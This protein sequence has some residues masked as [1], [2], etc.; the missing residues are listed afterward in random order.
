MKR[1]IKL[2]HQI[3]LLIS[4]LVIIP[5]LIIS[6]MSYVNLNNTINTNTNENSSTNITMLMNLINSVDTNCRASVDF[7][8]KDP[9]AMNIL[10]NKDSPTWLI[11]SFK[12]YY[13][14]HPEF[15]GVYMGV[16]DKR[17]L[18]IP[19]QNLPAG[20]DPTGRPW[21]TDAMAKSGQV[22][23]TAP[24]ED[25]AEKGKFVVTYAKQVIAADN[26]VVG[27]VAVDVT[28]KGLSDEVM[29]VK[30]GETGYALMLDDTGKV[31]ASG[32][33]ELIGLGSDKLPWLKDVMT[34]GNNEYKTLSID[35]AKYRVQKGLNP[36]TGWNVAIVVPEKELYAKSTTIITI[37]IVVAI[38]LLLLAILI[39]VIFSR[40]LSRPIGEFVKNI[41]K[42]QDG[43]FTE[44]VN[45]ENH[46]NYEIS[47]IAVSTNKMI[48]NFKQTLN[49]VVVS[50]KDVK[51]A[52]ESL[53]AI[54]EQS[55][56]AAEEV[57]KAIQDIAAGATNQAHDL[58]NGVVVVNHLGDQVNVSVSDSEKMLKSTDDVKK[59]ANDGL[60]T[61]ETL[62]QNFKE[63]FTANEKVANEVEILVQNFVKISSITDTIKSITDQT[64]LLALNASIEAAR[65]GEAGKGFAVV[66]EEVRKLAEQSAQSASEI[67]NVITE[68]KGSIDAVLKKLSESMELNRRTEESV[69]YTKQSFTDINKS[70]GLLEDSAVNVKKSMDIIS[71]NKNSVIQMINGVSGVSTDTAAASEQVSASSEEQLAA[72]Q[73][74]SDL[75]VK[76]SKLAEGLENSTKMFKL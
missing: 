55:H 59:V 31:I 1:K 52:A 19:E 44:K 48:D 46:M 39:G 5:I 33:K 40:T 24:Y 41:K 3:T 7:L 4:A 61:V 53:A 70:L 21:Y 25:A 54:T 45:Y 23:L 29:K 18:L 26:S 74:I 60:K 57:S 64:N 6:V 27:V 13:S 2:Q 56:M 75:F 63:T 9:N 12:G 37:T 47:T 51:E 73:E 68:I 66:A 34:L 15:S 10:T 16:S 32:K 76:L 30:L 71:Q 38:V 72:L 58:D 35:G 17:M 28:L 42:L 20:Y 62:T 11:G 49:G 50:S 69:S 67:Y 43:D 14:A 65:A 36:N 8:S 22:I